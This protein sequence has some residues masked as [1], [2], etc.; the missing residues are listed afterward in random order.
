MPWV[1]EEMC[2][3]C[4]IC[5]DECPVGAI[6]MP[7]DKANISEEDCIRCG[8]CH[9][10]CPQEAVRHDG[11]RIPEEVEDN[12]QWVRGL[13]EHYETQDEREG[14]VE[15]AKRLFQKN[16]KVAQQTVERLEGLHENL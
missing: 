10:V 12:V 3:G 16:Q 6:S 5:V 7:E 1:S 11:E 2:V 15:R 8:R 4:G 13:L 14:F 9:D